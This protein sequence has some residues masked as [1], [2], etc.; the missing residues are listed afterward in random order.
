MWRSG[1]LLPGVIQLGLRIEKR[2]WPMVFMFLMDIASRVPFVRFGGKQR[3]EQD[4]AYVPSR[5]LCRWLS[6]CR[7]DRSIHTCTLARGS[8]SQTRSPRDNSCHMHGRVC[9]SQQ[10]QGQAT[11]PSSDHLR[12][13]LPPAPRAVPPQGSDRIGS[14]ARIWSSCGWRQLF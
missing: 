8:R 5:R 13:G 7:F 3:V 11:T 10:T 2:A 6:P 12:H 9:T 14:R 4:R 1:E